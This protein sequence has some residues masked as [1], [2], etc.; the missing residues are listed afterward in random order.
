[1]IA[2]TEQDIEVLKMIGKIVAEIRDAMK[3]ATVPG[4][5][6][7]EL[8]EI[9]GRLFKEKGAVS[10]P[11]SEYDFPGYTC[12]S[13]DNEVAHGMPGPRVIKDGDLINIDVPDRWRLFR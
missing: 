1:M 4:I 7:K 13:V 10:A 9:G 11:I 8:D 2:K 6:T 12:I 5:T 3:E